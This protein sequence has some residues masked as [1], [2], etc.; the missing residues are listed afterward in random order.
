MA[1]HQAG[2]ETPARGCHPL[3][4]PGSPTHASL[5]GHGMAG[6]TQLHGKTWTVGLTGRLASSLAPTKNTHPRWS[7]MDD[8]TCS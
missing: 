4:L 6:S 5:E 2:R 3:L 7:W 8:R 1:R